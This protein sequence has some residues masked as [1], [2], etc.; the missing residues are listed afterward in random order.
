WAAALARGAG[1]PERAVRLLA[2]PT[3]GPG[4][5]ALLRD[6]IDLAGGRLALPGTGA[7]GGPVA[8]DAL[9][10]LQQVA[11]AWPAPEERA[12]IDLIAFALAVQ[13]G[14][15]RGALQVLERGLAVAPDAVP[16]ALA[17]ERLA[18]ATK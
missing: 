16:L 4:S 14:D 10:L 8:A 5:R 7:G 18:R 13:G 2:D 15:E 6:R 3:L 1:A 11:A 9:E 12:G 17:A